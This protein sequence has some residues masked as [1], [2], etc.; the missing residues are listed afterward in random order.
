MEWTN[1]LKSTMFFLL[2]FVLVVLLVLVA[3]A[4]G[5][6]LGY[7]I[8]GDGADPMEVF[9]PELWKHIFNFVFN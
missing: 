2:R 7:S 3:F 9:N 4:V 5:G 6:M 8:L 1:V